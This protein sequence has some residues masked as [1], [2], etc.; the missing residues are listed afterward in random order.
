MRST[1]DLSWFHLVTSQSLFMLS[2]SNAESRSNAWHVMLEN[3][4]TKKTR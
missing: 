4:T 2:G 1:V 3:T